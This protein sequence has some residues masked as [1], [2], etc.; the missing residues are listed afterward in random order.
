MNLHS[1]RV[2]SDDQQ[3][4]VAVNKPEIVVSISPKELHKGE[5][6]H[7]VSK[8]QLDD[9][10]LHQF[11]LYSLLYLL[12]PQQFLLL[13]LPRFLCSHLFVGLFFALS[14]AVSL[15]VVMNAHYLVS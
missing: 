11:R 4:F 15:V 13:E 5:L 10:I 12:L 7:G 3:V 14:A 9:L 1:F 8:M 2:P 6:N